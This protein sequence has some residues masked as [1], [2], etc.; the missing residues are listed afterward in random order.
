M[1]S[2]ISGIHRA[3]H[4]CSELLHEIWRRKLV[5][6]AAAYAVAGWIIIEI[7]SVVLPAFDAPQVF[8][9][10]IIGLVLLGFPV[11]LVFSWIFDMTAQGLVRTDELEESA[12]AE[13]KE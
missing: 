7:A 4:R 9:Q 2:R 6:A 11:V 1:N 10:S 12:D 13:E 5:Q 3:L 8:L